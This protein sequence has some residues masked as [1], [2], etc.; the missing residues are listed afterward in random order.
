MPRR[1]G[2][3]IV[4]EVEPVSS[5]SRI[6]DA[7]ASVLG[8]ERV[9][10]ADNTERGEPRL[11]I[12][13]GVPDLDLVLDRGR[14]GWPVGRIVEIY[15]AEATCK[16][17]VGYALI[18]QA[19]KLGGDAILYPA[20][21]NWDE[22]LAERYGVDLSKLILGDDP[23]VEG[24]FT[25]F[26]QAMQVTGTSGVLVG[27]IDSI[28]G[29]ST[30]DEL[31]ALEDGEPIKRDR[32]AQVRALMLSAALRKLGGII[33]RNNAILFCV[34]QVRE[35]PDV[36]YGEKKKPPGGMALK[37]YASI[38][39]RLEILGKYKRTRKGEKYVAGL[40]LK[41][42][43]EKN[44]LARPFQEAKILLDYDEGLLPMPKKK[45]E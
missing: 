36:V 32:A 12:P 42:T 1:R 15:G 2:K 43:A 44:R 4:R 22:W 7:V 26:N 3:K 8:T 35:N 20:E 6:A 18:G 9:H 30:R 21:G 33:P 41:V 14:R 39:L 16:T 37:F 25:S 28:A 24:V 19:Q 34:N 23:T 13:S 29:M 45:S 10:N 31:D 17:G 27:M 5:I 40:K 11:F 38:R